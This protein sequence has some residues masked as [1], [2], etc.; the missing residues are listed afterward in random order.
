MA[1]TQAVSCHIHNLEQ[2]EATASMLP[3]CVASFLRSS[4]FQSPSHE[5]VAPNIQN[6]PSASIH[7]QDNALQICLRTS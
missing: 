7:S 3:A 2:K 1:E 4:T 5:M 6:E